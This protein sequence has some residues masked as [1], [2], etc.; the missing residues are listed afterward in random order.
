MLGTDDRKPQLPQRATHQGET[1][2]SRGE[3]EMKRA[4]RGQAGRPPI[5]PDCACRCV[6]IATHQRWVQG[7]VRTVRLVSFC[8]AIALLA[9]VAGTA[10]ACA[11][12][13]TGHAVIA[14]IAQR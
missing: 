9:E 4:G 13:S 11:W 8:A 7:F 3:W 6:G 14:E 1:G 10:A 2:K 12:G 5:G